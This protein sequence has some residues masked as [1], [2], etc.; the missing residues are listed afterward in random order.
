MA[1]TFRLLILIYLCCS[2]STLLAQEN[3][4]LGDIAREYRAQQ[5]QRA[6]K[7]YTNRDLAR[8]SDG[9]A[10]MTA[11]ISGGYELP[12]QDVFNEVQKVELAHQGDLIAEFQKQQRLVQSLQQELNNSQR[13][14]ATMATLYYADV[15]HY[16]RNPDLWRKQVL[17]LEEL[18]ER[19]RDQV[20]TATQALDDLRE[21]M[22]RAGI[23]VRE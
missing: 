5:R 18:I 15:G 10:P 13:Q 22:R 4:S 20:G 21:R 6:S 14:Y 12:A 7:I 16:L 9:A 17:T 1:T 11:T 8:L 23:R 3:L 2:D 19:T